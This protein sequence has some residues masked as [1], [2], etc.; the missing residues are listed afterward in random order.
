MFNL[1]VF[2][3][4]TITDYMRTTHKYKYFSVYSITFLLFIHIYIYIYHI[5]IYIIY[6]KYLKNNFIA[7]VCV[8]KSTHRYICLVSL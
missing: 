5:N 7:F 1:L 4:F 6:I 8:C 3:T 2:P